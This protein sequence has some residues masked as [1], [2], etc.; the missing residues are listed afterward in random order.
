[1]A[2][3]P[4][5]S[6][7]M[8]FLD[9]EQFLDEAIRSVFAQTYENWELLLVNDGSGPAATEIAQR[10]AS[11]NPARVRYLQH[12]NGENRGMSASRNLG[13][14]QA[15]GQLVSLLDA[16]DIYAPAKTAEQ[17]DILLTHA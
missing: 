13:I 16:D 5:V 3:T 14:T 9:G 8:N 15:R 17:V 12:S 6:V 4:L 10:W 11:E 2:S 1:M 7:I